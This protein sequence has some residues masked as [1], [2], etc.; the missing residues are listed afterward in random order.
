STSYTTSVVV[1][2]VAPTGTAP[3]DQSSNEGSATSFDLGSFSEPGATDAPWHVSVDWGDGSPNT[4]FDMA[5]RGAIDAKNRTF[6]D[7]PHNYTV[8]ERGHDKDGGSDHN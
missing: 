8:T 1:H 4:T 7:G 2:N 6:D 3:N 5:S